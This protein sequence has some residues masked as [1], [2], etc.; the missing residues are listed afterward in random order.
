[1]SEILGGVLLFAIALFLVAASLAMVRKELVAPPLG[2]AGLLFGAAAFL[3]GVSAFYVTTYSAA[4]V[5]LQMGAG[6]ATLAW[7][8]VASVAMLA[9]P[10]AARAEA[11]EP[12]FASSS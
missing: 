12:V 3:S 5:G 10:E 6:I 11:P 4:W 8:L 7:V 1:M 9:R 2:Y